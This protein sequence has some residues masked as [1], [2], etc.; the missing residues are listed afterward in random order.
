MNEAKHGHPTQD[1][2]NRWGSNLKL[3]NNALLGAQNICTRRTTALLSCSRLYPGTTYLVVALHHQN[4]VIIVCRS[5]MTLK[6]DRAVKDDYL[7]K[8]VIIMIS[9]SKQGFWRGTRK[10]PTKINNTNGVVGFW[11][12]SVPEAGCTRKQPTNMI[13]KIRYGG[14]KL[15]VVECC[16][17]HE[18]VQ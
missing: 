3:D 13:T 12:H 6:P 15:T 9:Q 8:N 2:R 7:F 5:P 1:Y 10:Q 11:G 17:V 4:N 14:L 16:K 18:R